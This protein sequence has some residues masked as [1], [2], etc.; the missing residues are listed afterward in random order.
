LLSVLPHDR[1][2]RLEPYADAATLID[3]GA[4]D[5]NAPD[6]I[7]GG[8]YRGHQLPTLTRSFA[9]PAIMG[10]R[11]DKF[12]NGDRWYVVCNFCGS[13]T[14]LKVALWLSC[15]PDRSLHHMRVLCELAELPDYLRA[16]LLRPP[17]GPDLYFE[18]FGPKPVSEWSQVLLPHLVHRT[19]K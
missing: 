2:C 16:G 3:I 10:V 8:Q 17:W 6:N 7:F 19:V 1:G 15:Q 18:R 4:L 5:G 9:T 11:D 12:E 13:E 14:A